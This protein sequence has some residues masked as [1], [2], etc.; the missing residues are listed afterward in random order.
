MKILYASGSDLPSRKTNSI[1]AMN[2]CQGFTENNHEILLTGFQKKLD[3]KS[4]RTIHDFYN[5]K[6]NFKIKTINIA[7]L[8]K[9]LLT[10]LRDFI[11]GIY[12]Y[13]IIKKY[14]PEIVYSRLV[15]IDLLFVPNSVKVIYEM[16]S[17]G[18]ITK[19]SFESYIFGKLIQ[20]GKI[21]RIVTSTNQLKDFIQTKF[22]QL[23]I[24]VA[25]VGANTPP[26]L[27]SRIVNEFKINLTGINKLF[28]VGYAGHIDELRGMNIMIDIAK[29][30]PNITFHIVGG[31]EEDINYWK[32]KND[33][34]NIVFHGF[35]APNMVS[36]Y[37]ACFDVVLMPQ[38][39]R[40]ASR[41]PFGKGMSSLKLPE[42]LSNGCAIVASNI[43]VTHEVV[44]HEYDAL[45]AKADDINSW[46][47][48]I[49]DLQSDRAL[50]YRLKKNAKDTF[51]RN[52]NWTNRANKVLQNLFSPSIN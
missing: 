28:N 14:K 17:P 8:N 39:Y 20:L 25:R 43:P 29:R 35:V 48:C 11:Y 13:I 6:Q 16:H 37:L 30:M 5:V 52:H 38:Q 50:G 40:K 12:I 46:V 18:P 9:S 19:N 32:E 51:A 4:F 3:K 41:A 23:D 33:A 10:Y 34:E 15:F 47:K 2:M 49:S 42:Y 26:P 36:L 27:D 22:P 1:N 31:F 7:W 44:T 45:I 21:N 24:V